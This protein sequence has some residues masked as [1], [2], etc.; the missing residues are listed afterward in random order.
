[1]I[2]TLTDVLDLGTVVNVNA[3]H[4]LKYY[5]NMNYIASIVHL[6]P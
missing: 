5:I 1:M 2:F 4:A 3:S 6:N